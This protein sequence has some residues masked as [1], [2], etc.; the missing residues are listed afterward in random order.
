MPEYEIYPS[1]KMAETHGLLKEYAEK[2]AAYLDTDEADSNPDIARLQEA[3][4]QL[5]IKL[6]NLSIDELQLASDNATAAIDGISTATGVL[7]DALAK[8]AEITKYVEVAE[9]AII[10]VGAI[11]EKNPSKIINAAREFVEKLKVV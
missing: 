4:V 1:E 7:R 5:Q 2:L 6:S 11:W 9:G 10:F 3:N 8:R